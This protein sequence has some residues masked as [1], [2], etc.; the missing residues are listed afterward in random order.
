MIPLLSDQEIHRLRRSINHGDIKKLSQ[1]IGQSRHFS[2]CP[3]PTDRRPSDRL[4]R[5]CLTFL[6]LLSARE[7]ADYEIESTIP[8]VK[9]EEILDD[10][11]TCLQDWESLSADEQLYFAQSLLVQ[12]LGL[13]R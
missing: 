4:R 2:S 11:Q 9:A 10:A 5:I 7:E 1:R 3:L 6:S 12:M 13:R 8:L